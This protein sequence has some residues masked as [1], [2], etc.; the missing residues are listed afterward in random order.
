[1][2]GPAMFVS[3]GGALPFSALVYRRFGVCFGASG[4][5]GYFFGV[6]VGTL[7]QGVILWVGALGSTRMGWL[8]TLGQG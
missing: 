3:F 6:C 1:M 4:S 5:L 8:G 2:D 7:G